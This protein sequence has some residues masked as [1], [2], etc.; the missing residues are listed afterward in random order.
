MDAKTPGLFDATPDPVPARVIA[1]FSCGATSAV[2]AKLALGDY[3]DANDV[4]IRIASEHE[5]ADRFACDV[6][7]WLGREIVTL[8]PARYGDHFE[9]IRGERYINGPSGAKCTGVLK[10]QTREAYQRGGDLHVFGFDAGEASRVEDFRENNPGLWF[11]APLIDA[12]LTKSDCHN[13]LDRAGIKPHAMYELGYANANC[14]GC[15]KGG[16][17]YWNRIRVDFPAVFARM[18]AA[19]REIGHTVLRR[20]G[21][22]LY[23]DQLE[24]NAGRFAEDQ[25]GECGVLCQT[26]LARVG[27][28]TDPEAA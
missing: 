27:L 16:M 13:I 15:V 19:E 9:V 12:G 2:A 21:L 1:W 10:R 23:L 20:K 26:A 3:P 28:D 24:P 22:P 17:G 11:K 25:P 14:V 7:R 6:G 5:D 4:R 18:A 8:T